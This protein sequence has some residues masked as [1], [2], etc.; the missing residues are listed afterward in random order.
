MHT[1]QKNKAKHHNK[2]FKLFAFHTK[3]AKKS[4]SGITA[5]FKIL[6]AEN[7]INILHFDKGIK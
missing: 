6:G 1:E 2:L 3:N 5:V 4:N 7:M